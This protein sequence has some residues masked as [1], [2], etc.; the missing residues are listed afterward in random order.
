M[1][2]IALFIF[3]LSLPH[4][5]DVEP[6]LF[7]GCAYEGDRV[8]IVLLGVSGAEYDIALKIVSARSPP[9]LKARVCIVGCGSML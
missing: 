8:A 2:R 6:E 3:S 4:V 7:V 9:I 1:V 5:S